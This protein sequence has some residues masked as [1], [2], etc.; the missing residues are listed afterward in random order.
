MLKNEKLIAKK[1]LF[2]IVLLTITNRLGYAQTVD[3]IIN[4]HLE[5]QGFMNIKNIK[6]MKITGKIKMADKLCPFKM[7][8]KQPHSMRSEI[9]VDGKTVI[10]SFDGQ[11]GW[12]INPMDKKPKPQKMQPEMME[13]LKKQAAIFDSP[14]ADYKAK[15]IKISLAGTEKINKKKAYK[16]KITTK[17]NQELTGYIDVA[18]NMFVRSV[19]TM[20]KDNQTAIILTDFKKHKDAG[21]VKIPYDIDVKI[22]GQSAQEM[23]FNKIDVNTDLKNSIFSMPKN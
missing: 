14:F 22:N 16:L 13:Q 7:Y 12:F 9:T 11:V 1:I 2:L 10:Q 4:K 23:I 15:G 6:T 8:I 3:E 19:V 18:S 20:K 21:G 17:D 5:A